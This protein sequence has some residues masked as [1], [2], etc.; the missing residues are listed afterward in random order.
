MSSPLLFSIYI[1][2]LLVLLRQ[3]SLGCRLDKFFYGVLGYADDLLLLSASRSGLQAMV[4]ICE[5]FAKERKLKFSS[6]ANPAKSKTKC[7][8]FT[9]VKSC[10]VNFAPILLNSNHLPC[11]DKVK[12]LGNILEYTA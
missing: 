4:S 9:K 2:D 5:R 7:V 10:Q 3:S 12:H 8:I 6:N 1:D 11:V